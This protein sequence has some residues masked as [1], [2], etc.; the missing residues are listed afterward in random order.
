MT[1][2]EGWSLSRDDWRKLTEVLVN[3]KWR[4][5]WLNERYQD[6]VPRSAGIYLLITNDGT[7]AQQYGLPKGI[8]NVLYVGRSDCLRDRFKQHTADSQRTTAQR[9]PLLN[10]CKTTFG[11]LRY[12]FALVPDNAK[13]NVDEWLRQVENTLTTVFSP[14]VNSN[15]PKGPEIKARLGTPQAVG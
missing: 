1:R 7:I 13:D 9:N 8:S 12:L 15:V 11:D 4:M 10:A 3:V 14:P 2:L 5:T 6:S